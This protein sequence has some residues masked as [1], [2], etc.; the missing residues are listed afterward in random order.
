MQQPEEEFWSGVPGRRVS[1]SRAAAGIRKGRE[2]ARDDETMVT[3]K[4]P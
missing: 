4:S 1:E 3:L 2:G